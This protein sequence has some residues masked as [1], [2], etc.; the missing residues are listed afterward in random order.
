MFECQNCG[1][2]LTGYE[3][4]CPFCGLAVWHPEHCD[5]EA[6]EAKL[7]EAREMQ[8]DYLLEQQEW[9]DFEGCCEPTDYI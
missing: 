3:P 6:C 7:E 5:C 4:T 9:D 8:E 1:R 2:E